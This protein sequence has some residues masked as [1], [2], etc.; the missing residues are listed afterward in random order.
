MAEPVAVAEAVA[1]PEPV[2]RAEPDEME[3]MENRVAALA[4]AAR[5][6]AETATE[7]AETLSLLHG[8]LSSARKRRAE[9]RV[10]GPTPKRRRSVFW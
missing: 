9:E 4:R 7:L 5:T 10:P 1:V 2:E 6:I 3:K 8:S